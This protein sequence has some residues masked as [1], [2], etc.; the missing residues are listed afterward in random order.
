[1]A[2]HRKEVSGVKERR[3]E[4]TKERERELWPSSRPAE[5][6]A[7]SPAQMERGGLLLEKLPLLSIMAFNKNR[8]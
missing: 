3:E 1:M 2:K 4:R 5:P 6:S 8:V 7:L